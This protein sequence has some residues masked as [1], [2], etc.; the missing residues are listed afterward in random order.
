MSQMEVVLSADPVTNKL[1]NGENIRPFTESVWP[2]YCYL[3]FNELRSN[4]FTEP[5]PDAER[6]K[7]PVSWNFTFQTGPVCTSANV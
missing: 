5:S 7:S 1:V 6:T 2:L 4:N 3:A